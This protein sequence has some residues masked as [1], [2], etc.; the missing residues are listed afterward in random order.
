M[1][2]IKYLKDLDFYEERKIIDIDH[3]KDNINTINFGLLSLNPNAINILKNNMDKIN[4]NNLSLNPNAISIL[5]NNLDKVNWKNL[6]FNPNAILILG[7]NM[8]KINWFTLSVNPNAILLLESNMDKIDWNNL[9][10]NPNAIPLLEKNVDKI[11]FT[12]ISLNEN[13]KKFSDSIFCNTFFKYSDYFLNFQHKIFIDIRSQCGAKYILKNIYGKCL[14]NNYKYIDFIQLN[15]LI[16]IMEKKCSFTNNYR[17]LMYQSYSSFQYNDF[18]YHISKCKCERNCKNDNTYIC[19]RNFKSYFNNGLKNCDPEF[20]NLDSLYENNNF[21]IIKFL[22]KEYINKNLNNICHLISEPKI[23]NWFFLQNNLNGIELFSSISHQFNKHLVHLCGN[24]NINAISYLEKNLDKLDDDC[25]KELS[26]NANAIS[27][28]KQNMHKIN[29]NYLSLNI[30]AI[31]ILEKKI[32][33][34]KLIQKESILFLL[35]DNFDNIG[36]DLHSSINIMNK[37][38][39]KINY[40][41]DKRIDKLDLELFSNYNNI[42]SILD[43]EKKIIDTS[44]NIIHKNFDKINYDLNERIDKLDLELFSNYN[45][46][47]RILDDEKKRIDN[48]YLNILNMEATNNLNLEKKIDRLDL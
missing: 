20:E 6:S 47:I 43:K 15:K 41:L 14:L 5:E 42:I 48:L 16:D 46:V 21:H 29:W 37:K 22:E 2:L 45:N 33:S 31:D 12:N 40:D 19:N 32:G 38:I 8:D 30:N 23:I 7:N 17:D 3:F 44:I 26:K 35:K 11:N 1:N 9:S 4:W 28:L 27:I 13:L 18:S 36:I 24:N 34:E 39:D 10:L 25:W